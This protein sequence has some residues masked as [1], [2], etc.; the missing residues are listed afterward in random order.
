[1]CDTTTLRLRRRRPAAI[2]SG[3]GPSVKAETKSAHT[4]HNKKKDDKYITDTSDKERKQ[5]K[6]PARRCA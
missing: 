4:N 3:I 2:N 1:M 6:P 5:K